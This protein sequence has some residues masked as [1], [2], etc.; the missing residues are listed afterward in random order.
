MISS[1]CCGVAVLTSTG[2]FA[3]RAFALRIFFTANENTPLRT[4]DMERK[5]LHSLEIEIIFSVLCVFC[6]RQGLHELWCI[7]RQKKVLVMTTL[8]VPR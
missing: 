7:L 8:S 5:T 3:K 2:Q 6:W 1:V 4:A